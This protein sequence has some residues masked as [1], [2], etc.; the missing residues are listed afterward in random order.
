MSASSES[1]FDSGDTEAWSRSIPG[2][3]GTLFARVV[4]QL[5]NYRIAGNFGK[6]FN[7][8]F[9]EFQYTLPACPRMA[10]SI[11][12]TKLNFANSSGLPFFQVLMLAEVT[13]YMVLY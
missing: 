6:V 5:H 7:L 4:C 11:Q 13:S 2:N 1:E 3:H 8:R 12:I 9:G 10:V